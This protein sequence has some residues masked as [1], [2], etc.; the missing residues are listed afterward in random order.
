MKKEN[1]QKK[2][3]VLVEYSIQPT[4]I[5]DAIAGLTKLIE[6]VTK[7]PHFINIKLHTDVKDNSK[8]LLYEIWN[9]ENYYNTE[10]MQT[11]H[12][13]EFIDDSRAFLAG[14]PI[15]SQWKI[16]NEFKPE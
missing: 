5:N 4:K 11:I 1:N 16:E 6:K 15:I 9:D 10:H 13:K 8:I 3:V 7:E 12:L 2:L 14:P